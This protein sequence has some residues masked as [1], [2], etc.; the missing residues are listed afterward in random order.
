MELRIDVTEDYFSY[1]MDKTPPQNYLKVVFY[2]PGAPQAYYPI[3]TSGLHR[4]YKQEQLSSFKLLQFILSCHK[5]L[6]L[7]QAK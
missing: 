4:V 5:R 1:F 7:T 2:S 6:F 3:D